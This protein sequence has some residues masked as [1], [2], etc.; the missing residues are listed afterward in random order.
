MAA[1]EVMLAN[2]AI[3]SL[4]RENKVP[5]MVSTMQ[6]N[7]ASGMITMDD[8][9]MTLYY[10]GTISGEK[11]IEFAIDKVSMKQKIGL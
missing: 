2:N 10:Q 9:L 1:F 7:R 5:Q 8:Y 6:T 4:I 3:R 11:A